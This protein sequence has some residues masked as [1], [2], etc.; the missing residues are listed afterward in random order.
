MDESSSEKSGE[1]SQRLRLGSGEGG[2]NGGDD[3]TG[4]GGC[5]RVTGL[6]VGRGGRAGG[7]TGVGVAS[8]PAEGTPSVVTVV[9]E[10]EAAPI[11]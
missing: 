2:E 4:F 7:S 6:G 5:E 11:D 8:C 3:R 9:A 1:S 10:V